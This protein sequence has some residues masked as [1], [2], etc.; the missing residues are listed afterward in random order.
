MAI[1]IPENVL[2]YVADRQKEFQTAWNI[3]QYIFTIFAFETFAMILCEKIGL[4]GPAAWMIYVALPIAG[5]VG[6]II[7]GQVLIRSNYQYLFMKKSADIN[8]DWKEV[9][10]TLRYLKEKHP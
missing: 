10:E 4:Y 3:L 5:F 2:G 6:V 9:V 8:N 1:T 7:V